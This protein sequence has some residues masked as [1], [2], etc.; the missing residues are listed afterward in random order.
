L[1]QLQSNQLILWVFLEKQNQ[2]FFD[3]EFFKEPEPVVLWFQILLNQNQWFFD[4]EFL[5]EPEPADLQK[6]KEPA[7]TSSE[8]VDSASI[9]SSMYFP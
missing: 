2:R 7:D 3:S 4:S 5:S 6:F 8:P 1:F 9:Q